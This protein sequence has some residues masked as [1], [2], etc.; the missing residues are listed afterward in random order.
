M[1]F[2]RKQFTSNPRLHFRVGSILL[3]FL[4]FFIYLIPPGLI[5]HS[6]HD[7]LGPLDR[8]TENDPCHI[9]IYHPGAA[10]ACHHKYHF[11]PDHAYCPLCHITLVRQ[12]V[13]D[14]ILIREITYCNFTFEIYCPSGSTHQFPI[15]HDDRGPPLSALS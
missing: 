4:Y 14:T 7:H 13:P 12:I 11:I 9:A 10:G 5:P 6:E 15:L 3:L 8:N 2:Q 1:E